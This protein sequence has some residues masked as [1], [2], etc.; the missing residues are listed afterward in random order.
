MGFRGLVV[1]DEES[2]RFTFSE[3]L[4][5]AGYAVDVAADVKGAQTLMATQSYDVVFLDI[6][7]GTESGLDV[8][9]FSKEMNPNCPVIMVTG[10]PE[11]STAAASVRLSAFDYLVKPVRENELILHAERAIAFKAA[12]DE[13]ERYQQRLQK[14]FEG[15]AEG[16]LVF[17]ARMTLSDINRAAQKML[18]LDSNVIGFPL[19]DLEKESHVMRKIAGL[20]GSRIEGEIFRIN[21]SDKV[22][23]PLLL[24]VSLSPLYA[25]SGKEGDLVVVL[26][27]ETEPV[28]DLGE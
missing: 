12:L 5:D 3:F 21:C 25:S 19:A 22:D 15:V 9:S 11:V 17:D 10:A 16:L 14:V 8:L 1:D 7:L 2:I 26:R 4:A 20:I 6:M 24:S 27:D 13:K 28:R 18:Q 23:Q